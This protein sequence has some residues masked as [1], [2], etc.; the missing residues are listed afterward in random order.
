MLF[1]KPGDIC[2]QISFQYLEIF[3][4][5]TEAVD[6][7]VHKKILDKEKSVFSSDYKDLVQLFKNSI[8]NYNNM[9]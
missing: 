9:L 8:L 5:Y 6:N 3:C 1:F 7:S 4:L 2:S